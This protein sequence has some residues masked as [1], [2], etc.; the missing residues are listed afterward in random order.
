MKILIVDDE[1]NIRES[2]HEYLGLEGIEADEA[3]NGLA[4][5]RNLQ[6]D[7]FDGAIL[8]LKMPGMGGLDLLAWINQQGP[9]I[10]VVMIS[11]FG[12][13]E[14]AVEAMKL[15]AYDYIVKPF[16]P[17]ELVIRIKQAVEKRKLE[18]RIAIQGNRGDV[19]ARS[20]NPRMKEM[21]ALIE[22][23]APSESTILITGESGTGK[24]VVAR[25]IHAL[26]AR[27]ANSFVP[28]N[29][30][31]IPDGLLESELFGYEKGAFTGAEKRKIGMFELASKGTLFLDEIGEMPLHLQVKL[32]RVIQDKNIQR[33]G[34]VGTIPIDVRIVAATNKNLE[35][36][37]E[38]GRFREDLYYRLNVIRIEI[39]PLRERPDDVPLLAAEFIQ[40]MQE[41]SG[42]RVRGITDGA[43]GMLKQYRFPGNVREL[44][45]LIERAVILSD[46]EMLT[47]N[48]FL[49]HR[50]DKQARK[51]PKGSLQ[52]IEREAIV[53]ALYR[54]EGKRQAA[55]DELGIT[56][57][58]LL[59]KIKEYG[60]GKE[61]GI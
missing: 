34:G 41:R 23:A 10:P 37:V 55:A 20:N 31:G 12:E 7:V 3:D 43:L 42:K 28:I 25:H 35:Q 9:A 58:T 17:Q 38:A 60:I 30:G 22:K 29:L 19:F 33:L 2:I 53:Q 21:A 40:N 51:V 61:F 27:A 16:D 15:G 1:K 32:L 39:P 47:E 13:V 8:D 45:N 24:E 44:E 56:R 18:D 6:E 14:D 49:I 5:Q 52:D 46:S 50:E 57:R 4:A 59:N 36:E 11:A 54:H 26:S 48:D